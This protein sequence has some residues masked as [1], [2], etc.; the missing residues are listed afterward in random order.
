FGSDAPVEPIDPLLGIHAAVARR[1]PGDASRWHPEQ[2]L[3]LEEALAAY[4]SGTAYA[5]GRERDLGT[6]AEGMRCDATVVD[7]DITGV[8]EPGLLET[9]VRATVVGGVVRYEDGL[10]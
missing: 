7:R 9:R 4:A 3:T 2:A 1:R 10:A 8:D 6:L 5:L